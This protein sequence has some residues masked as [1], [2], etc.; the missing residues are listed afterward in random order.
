MKLNIDDRDIH[1]IQQALKLAQ[2]KYEE[3]AVMF[4]AIAKQEEKPGAVITRRGAELL[5]TQFLRQAE[6]VQKLRTKLDPSEEDGE[7]VDY[8]HG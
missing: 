3:D 5:E 2:A 1:T 4:A 7:D 8:A 6:D